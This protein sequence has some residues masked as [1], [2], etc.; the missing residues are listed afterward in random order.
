VLTRHACAATVFH[1]YLGAR[2]MADRIIA[3][4]VNANGSQ[5]SGNN[6]SVT[7]TSEGHYLVSFRPAYERIDGASVTQIFNDGN[8]RDNAVII[9]LSATEL[10]LKTGDSNG[11]AKDRDFSFV[12]A[13]TGSVAAK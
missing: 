13:G 11:D 2:I 4:T 8:T 7:R 12:S 3:G 6:F 5:Q 1:F 9:R 10:F